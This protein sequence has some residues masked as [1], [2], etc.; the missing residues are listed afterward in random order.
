VWPLRDH[1]LS[2]ASFRRDLRSCGAVAWVEK[3]EP[4]FELVQQRADG[5]YGVQDY[6]NV[7]P[8]DRI[9]VLV[10]GEWRLG[11]VHNLDAFGFMPASHA[12]SSSSIGRSTANIASGAGPTVTRKV[13]SAR[14]RRRKRPKRSAMTGGWD[15]WKTK[16]PAHYAENHGAAATRSARVHDSSRCDASPS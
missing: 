11:I 16:L 9:E 5:W 4:A 8:G 6:E 3:H 1:I 14:S 12:H 13:G 7:H 10:A 2:P 15:A